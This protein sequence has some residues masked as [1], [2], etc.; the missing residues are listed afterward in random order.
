MYTVN[1][2][3]FPRYV[4]PTLRNLRG[5]KWADLVDRVAAQPECHEDTLAFM[6]M[7]IRLN[8]CMGC[9]TDSYRAMRGCGACAHQTLR[10][11][12]GNDDELLQLFDQAL[13]D[14]RHYIQENVAIRILA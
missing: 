1:E 3:L 6:L 4:I 8:G 12:K 5:Q 10:R 2:L 13:L 9:E 11:Y 14:I 7:M